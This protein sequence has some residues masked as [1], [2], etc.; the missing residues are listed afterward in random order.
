MCDLEIGGSYLPPEADVDKGHS[1]FGFIAYLLC[2][3]LDLFSKPGFLVLFS[4][5]LDFVT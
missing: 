4:I 5:L 3:L 1:R 2:C